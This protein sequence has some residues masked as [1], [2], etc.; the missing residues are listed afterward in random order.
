MVP[1]T[2]VIS[3]ISRYIDEEIVNKLTGY[4]K[5]VVGAGAGIMLTKA[6]NIFNNLKINPIIKQMELINDKD[7]VDIE[8]I[9]RE[10]KKQ[11]QKSAVTVD[12]PLVGTLTLNEQDVDKLYSMIMGG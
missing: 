6:T 12:I 8:T 9:Y 7:E 5:W 4:Q 1:Y 2:K 3:G 11:A 10:I